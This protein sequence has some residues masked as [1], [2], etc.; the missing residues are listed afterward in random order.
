[1]IFACAATSAIWMFARRVPQPAAS[2]GSLLGAAPG[3]A[4]MWLGGI[5]LYLLYSDFPVLVVTVAAGAFA[6]LGT[7]AGYAVGR[8]FDIVFRHS[9]WSVISLVA[10]V[11]VAV[12]VLAFFE[13]RA[14]QDHVSVSDVNAEISAALPHGSTEQAI[15]DYLDSKNINHEPV[16]VAHPESNGYLTGANVP[17][18]TLIIL[19]GIYQDAT[20]WDSES[21]IIIIFVLTPDR[22]L[23]RFFVTK[24]DYG[25]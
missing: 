23:E 17:P 6:A 3:L 15:L 14:V 8:L 12:G 21:Q 5:G 24:R 2:L 4:A 10:A 18:N 20:L 9:R 1:M 16:E 22:R 13:W 11:V 19:A 25:S 7:G